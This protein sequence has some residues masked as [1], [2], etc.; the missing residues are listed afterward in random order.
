[1]SRLFD[2]IARALAVL[3]AICFVVTTPTALFLFNLRQ[4]GFD[5]SIYTQ[6]LASSQF[7]QRLPSLLGEVLSKDSKAN[8]IPFV[9]ALTSD[10]WAK[11]IQTLLPPEELQAMTQ[12]GI[13]QFFAYLNG[14]AD[15]PHVSL[16]PFKQRLAGAPG[17]NAAM[18][19][20][21]SQPA[22]TVDQLIEVIASFGKVLCNP[23]QAILNA[24][25]PF[26]KSQLSLAAES[27]PDQISFTPFGAQTSALQNLRLIKSVMQISPLVPLAFLF[28]VAIFAVRTFKDWFEWW[29][30]SCSIAGVTSTIFTYAGLPLI[31]PALENYIV[32]QIQFV[33]PPEFSDAIKTIT[34][35]VLQRIFQPMGWQSLALSGIGF[36]MLI[37]A[38]I[39]SRVNKNQGIK[40]SDI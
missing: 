22:C 23:P 19:F 21:H 38:I 29:G 24:G 1:M 5:A 15:N 3:C 13:T 35:A 37:I 12:E 36:T 28:G 2:S 14:G 18:N 39:I 9:E 11:I 27:I 4:R 8:N 20:I 10:N 26:I 33:I 32:G 25:K 31:R 16:I 40:L 6:A 30:W 7:Y 34:E 17:L